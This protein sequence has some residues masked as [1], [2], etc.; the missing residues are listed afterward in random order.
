MAKTFWGRFNDG[1]SR[2]RDTGEMAQRT[3]ICTF[4]GDGV[5]A[6]RDLDSGDLLI[7]RNNEQDSP[8]R[9]AAFHG[10]AFNAE[11]YDD[12][13][14][15]TELAVF[16]SSGEAIATAMTGDRRL[17]RD[18][19]ARPAVKVANLVRAPAKAAT[20]DMARHKDTGPI[21]A[22]Q[23]RNEALRAIWHREVRT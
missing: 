8:E 20:R 6:I 19:A 14:G 4:S 22:M 9:V 1:P 5:T 10:N 11:A 12:G 21:A 2:M 18:A 16:H 15:Q 17:A 7:M 3:K 13:E 23:K